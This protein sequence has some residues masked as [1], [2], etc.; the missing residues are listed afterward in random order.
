MANAM[1]AVG[2]GGATGLHI[3]LTTDD[4]LRR[5]VTIGAVGLIVLNA[6]DLLLTRHLLAA[7]AQEGNPFMAGIISGNWGIVVKIVIPMLLALR[8]L[9]APLYRRAAL[10]LGFAVVLYCGVVA[11]NLH[12]MISH[13]A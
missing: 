13:A 12:V 9:T 4:D 1:R 11:W 8:Y 5:F 10:G 6:C 7:G 2:D 3:G